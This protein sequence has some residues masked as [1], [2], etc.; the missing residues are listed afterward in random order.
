[1]T[2]SDRRKCISFQRQAIA[3]RTHISISIAEYL[4][5]CIR[6]AKF[7]GEGIRLPQRIRYSPLKTGWGLLQTSSQKLKR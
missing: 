7:I 6:I 4:I 5:L 1:M 2:L 3:E